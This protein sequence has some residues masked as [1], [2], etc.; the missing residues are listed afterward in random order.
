MEAQLARLQQQGDYLSAQF[1]AM[2]KST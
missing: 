1:S 2:N